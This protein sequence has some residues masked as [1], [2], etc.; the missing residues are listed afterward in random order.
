MG[1]KAWLQV[2]RTISSIAQQVPAH[3]GCNHFAFFLIIIVIFASSYAIIYTKLVK[4]CFPESRLFFPPLPISCKSSKVY[5]RPFSKCL[6]AK[7]NPPFCSRLALMRSWPRSAASSM[8]FSRGFGPDI[9]LGAGH[10]PFKSCLPLMCCLF[11]LFTQCLFFL[12]QYTLLSMIISINNLIVHP[13]IFIHEAHQMSK[14]KANKK[15]TSRR[16]MYL[17]V[18][19]TH[20]HLVPCAK[21]T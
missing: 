12:G 6:C 3:G 8:D 9:M 21:F 18:N 4:I 14:P 17:Q 16:E 10:R 15:V 1:A 11:F 5:N 7:A 2:G 19:S 20:T 13:D